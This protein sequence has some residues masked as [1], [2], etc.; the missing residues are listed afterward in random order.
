L[1]VGITFSAQVSVTTTRTTIGIA[2]C[3]VA[4]KTNLEG[5]C[6]HRLDNSNLLS[7]IQNKLEQLVDALIDIDKPS[8]G[9]IIPDDT[10]NVNKKR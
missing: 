10:S 7:V 6:D 9:Q 3:A 4:P 8:D 1:T 5:Y 2:A